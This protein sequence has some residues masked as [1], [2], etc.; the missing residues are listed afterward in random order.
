MMS[1]VSTCVPHKKLF[2]KLIYGG[3]WCSMRTFTKINVKCPH[4]QH[5][6]FGEML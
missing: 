4:F 5:F 3:I 1:G 2:A 6:N